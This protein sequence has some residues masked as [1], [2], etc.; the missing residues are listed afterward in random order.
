MGTA[1]NL[2]FAQEQ[3]DQPAGWGVAPGT[4]GSINTGRRW[5]W[6]RSVPQQGKS[7]A[8]LFI[9]SGLSNARLPSTGDKIKGK[10][11]NASYS[12]N[13]IRANRIKPDSQV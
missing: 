7:L 1:K 5:G 13:K 4:E 6:G 2:G 11:K 8:F 12:P 3:A 10:G 9:T